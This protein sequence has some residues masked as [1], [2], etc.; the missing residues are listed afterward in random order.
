MR[1]QRPGFLLRAHLSPRKAGDVAQE[2]GCPIRLGTWCPRPGVQQWLEIGVNSLKTGSHGGGSPK[3]CLRHAPLCLAG[4]WSEPARGERACQRFSGAG[5]G[6]WSL[7]KPHLVGGLAPSGFLRRPQMTRPLRKKTRSQDRSSIH[8]L[9][10]LRWLRARVWLPSSFVCVSKAFRQ[11]RNTQEGVLIR[12]KPVLPTPSPSSCLCSPG[13]RTRSALRVSDFGA[14]PRRGETGS[15]YLPSGSV[16]RAL[17][18]MCFL[19]IK[20][21]GAAAHGIRSRPGFHLETHIRAGLTL[22]K[23]ICTWAECIKL[24]P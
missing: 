24:I 14:C 3:L 16:P 17:P 20:G 22:L 19:C 9:G 5:A 4:C 2:G 10:T 21:R 7:F 13:S 15:R 6:S 11:A 23:G 12:G 18:Q 1:P 8:R